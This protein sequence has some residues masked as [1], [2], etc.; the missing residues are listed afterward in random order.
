MLTPRLYQQTGHDELFR[1]IDNGQRRICVTAPTGAGKSWSLAMAIMEGVKRKQRVSLYTYRSVLIPQLSATL[2]SFGIPHGIRASGY[3]PDLNQDVQISMFQTEA[4]RCL[5]KRPQ[6]NLHSAKLVLIDEVHGYTAGITQQIFEHHAKQGADIVGFTATPADIW[7]LF[8]D[9]LIITKNSELQQMGVHL[10]CHEYAP[11]EPD[12]KGMR[13][14]PAGEF[15]EGDVVKKIMVPT[16]FGRVYKHYCRLNPRGLPGILFGPSVDGSKYFCEE[17]NGH[18]VRAAHIDASQI[19][20]GYDKKSGQPSVDASSEKNRQ[21]VLDQIRNGE[22][23]LLC[24]RF[25]LT[26]GLDCPEMHIAIMATCFGSVKTFL[27]AGGRLLRAHDSMAYTVLQDHGGN[28]WRHGSLNDDRAWEVGDTSAKIFEERQQRAQAGEEICGITCPKCSYVRLSGP[29]CHNC[30]H[31]HS[32]SSR[33][34]VQT[35]GTLKRQ[36]GPQ[37]KVKPQTSEGLKAWQQ[38]YWRSQNSK[39]SK[40]MTFNQIW[41]SFKKTHAELMPHVSVDQHGRDRLAIVNKNTNQIELLPFHPP[42]GDT[43]VWSQK[44]RDVSIK[45]LLK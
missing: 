1:R 16:V 22:L 10:P 40:A 25:V 20:Y 35:D 7:H 45:D 26:E 24:N 12:V 13:R 37:I 18:G 28:I 5:K 17:F 38:T 27:Q 44:V 34:V 29:K 3:E 4:A 9:L 41:A 23:D 39:S 14:T 19:Y 42:I 30:G 36:Y 21:R 6:W 8:D 43:F 32:K 31:V 2:S 11:D 15:I 33:L